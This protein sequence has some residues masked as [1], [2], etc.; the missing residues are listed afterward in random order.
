M[1]RP[2]DLK[3][4]QAAFTR[5]EQIARRFPEIQTI[6]RVM[7]HSQSTLVYLDLGGYDVGEGVPGVANPR[8]QLDDTLTFTRKGGLGN[9][10]FEQSSR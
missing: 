5:G 1:L 3:K 10:L 2:A 4:S 7:T 9:G 6:L 8:K